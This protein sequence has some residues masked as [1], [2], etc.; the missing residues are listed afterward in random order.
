VS[1]LALTD[2]APDLPSLASVGGGEPRQTGHTGIKAL[3]VAV[4]ENGIA[5]YLSPGGRRQAEAARWVATAQR[6]S[7]F[8]FI[9]VCETL[10]LDPAA[11]RARLRHLRARGDS[12]RQALGRTRSNAH[13]TGRLQPPKHR[14]RRLDSKRLARRK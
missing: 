14:R 11:V 6:R 4:L 9:D 1:K 8:S 10:G 13:H 2:I 7:P 3:M 5:S 12:A